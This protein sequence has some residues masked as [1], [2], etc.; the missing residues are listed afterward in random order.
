MPR[1]QVKMPGMA[2]DAYNPSAVE[3]EAGGVFGAHW[4]ASLL[5]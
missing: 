2:V 3:V 1:T 4:L 5:K